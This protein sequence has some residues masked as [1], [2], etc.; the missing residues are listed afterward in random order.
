MLVFYAVPNV[1]QLTSQIGCS[2]QVSEE[3]QLNVLVVLICPAD[4]SD[5]LMLYFYLIKYSGIS[6]LEADKI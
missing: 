6:P 5:I 3:L 4:N 1:V 2:I